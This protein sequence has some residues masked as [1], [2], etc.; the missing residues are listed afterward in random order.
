MRAATIVI[1]A[2]VGMLACGTAARAAEQAGIEIGP[3]PGPARLAGMPAVPWVTR[4]DTAWLQGE[5]LV[6]MRDEAR[7]A[8]ARA[9]AAVSDEAILIHV[10]VADDVHRGGNSGGSIWQ[11]DCVRLGVDAWGDDSH[12][13]P[14]DAEVVGIGDASYTFSLTDNG[15]VTWVEVSGAVDGS[16]VRP[17]LSPRIKRDDAA[18]TTTYDVEL[19][20][21]EFALPG[22]CLPTFGLALYVCDADERPEMSKLRWDAAPQA[23]WDDRVICGQFK[24]GLFRQLRIAEPKHTV[25]CVAITNR[26]LSEA[27]HAAEAVVTCTPGAAD[28]VAVYL[29]EM[30]VW[31][32]LPD[33]GGVQRLRVAA[34]PEE[35]LA[36]STDFEV[37][38]AKGGSD[39]ASASGVVRSD[40]EADWYAFK[41]ENDTGASAIGMEDWVE[42][43]AGEHGGVRMVA[44]R[45][46]FE[47]GTPVKFWGTNIGSGTFLSGWQRERSREMLS[48]YARHWRKYGVNCIRVHKHMENTGGILS[49]ESVLEFDPEKLDQYDYFTAELKKNGIYHAHSPVF[50]LRLG[51]ADADKV[52]AYDEIMK[53]Q[54]D[55]DGNVPKDAQG[56]IRRRGDTYCFSSFAP[57][58]Q[59]VHIQQTVNILN[60]RNP[61][62]GLRYAEDPALAY[63]ELRNEDSI[64]FYST[65]S[66]LLEAPTYK[67]LFCERFSD[68]LKARYDTQ[69]AL[70]NA[71]GSRA[72]NCW[73]FCYPDECLEKRNIFPIC[74]AWWFSPE[75][76]ADQEESFGARRRLLDTARFL[77]EEQS[78]FYHRFVEAIR[79]TGFEGPIVGSCWWAGSGVPHYLNLYTDY[80][81][82]YIDRHEYYGG[83]GWGGH[84]SLSGASPLARP[85]SGS[86][87]EGFSQVVDRPFGLSEWIGVHPYPWTADGPP[88]I[89]AY[90]LGLQGWDASYEFASGH[91]GFGDDQ[92]GR[93]NVQRPTQLGQYPTIARM[94]YRKDVKEGPVISTRNIHVPSVLEGRLGFVEEYGMGQTADFN[95]ISGDIPEA[96]LAAGRVVVA[97]TE[98]F[99]DTDE[100][101]VSAYVKDGAVRSVTGQLAWTGVDA[102]HDAPARRT[103]E[104]QQ[105]YLTIDTP[106][107]KALVGFAPKRPFKLGEVTI[108]PDNLFAVVFVTAADKDATIANADRLIV[109]AVARAKNTG[110]IYQPAMTMSIA[111]RGQ[112]PVLMEPV[113]ATVSIS[114]PGEA[115]VN[116]LDH[117]GRRTGRTLPVTDGAFVIDG[118]RDRTLYYEVVYR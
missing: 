100:F 73:G 17:N 98:E 85:G 92:G 77:Y 78:R 15:P 12:G 76:L 23:S 74:N 116:V 75:G 114:R 57:D 93:W 44:D 107:T 35:R 30:S 62:T 70:E 88:M 95:A 37:A 6:S 54:R 36:G 110:M 97:F 99:R 48:E 83:G 53:P 19:P 39:V 96:A 82:G 52:V 71:W 7:D 40:Y 50:H 41:P 46:E 86:L 106:G 68:W 49:N 10:I 113:R 58:V 109:S 32:D 9:W 3:L 60:H 5:P 56:N 11:N 26:M 103:W 94:V 84:S 61:H 42:A 72:F 89:A 117:D 90:G 45:F 67:K 28:E 108:E 38:L 87:I 14:A 18:K 80:E 27:R 81:V 43:P 4:E 16:G 20:W 55:K 34:R 101:D 2:A 112:G 105:G 51:P 69:G 13:R 21:R 65:Q 64:F 31:L 59:D 66:I 1:V 102:L 104:D 63:V 25:A 24:P 115:T 118:S 22:C 47:D 79:G 29:G 8:A 111:E 91:G 33:G